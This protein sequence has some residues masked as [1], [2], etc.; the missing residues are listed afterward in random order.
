MSSKR[1]NILAFAQLGIPILPLVPGGSQPA[2]SGRLNGPN[3]DHKELQR[4]FARHPQSNY[5][6]AAGNGFFLV[7]AHGK[8]GKENL[9]SLATRHGDA[10]P[11]TVT[12]RTGDVQDYVFRCDGTHVRNSSGRL[13]KGI[14]VFGEG[15]YVVGPGST[16]SGAKCRFVQGLAVDEVE[17]APAP[18]WLL[19]AV[20][21]EQVPANTTSS[22]AGAVLNTESG[23]AAERKSSGDIAVHSNE[24]ASTAAPADVSGCSPIGNKRENGVPIS[25]R[26]PNCELHISH[27][28]ELVRLPIEAVCIDPA[29]PPCDPQ[30]VRVLADSIRVLGLRTPISVRKVTKLV[31]GVSMAALMLVAG[32]DRYEATKS[33]GWDFIDAFV[34]E[35]DVKNARLWQIAENVH[36]HDVPALERAELID[37]FDRL[38]EESVKGGQVAHP[39][40]GGRQPK[41]KGLSKAAKKLGITRE[42][43][44]RA[45]D[46]AGLSPEAKAKVKELGL[47][48]NQAALLKIAQEKVPHAQVA[49]A[50]EIAARKAVSKDE[51]AKEPIQA[52][53]SAPG[54]SSETYTVPVESG[55]PAAPEMRLENLATTAAAEIDR[56]K[57]E[58][59]DK[60]HRLRKAEEEL[61]VARLPSTAP[62]LPETDPWDIPASL[63][64]R[65]LSP[66][67]EQILAVLLAKWNSGL[68][69]DFG[70][71][72]PVVRERFLAEVRRG[73]SDL[74]PIPTGVR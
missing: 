31:E 34:F 54:A 23:D 25:K 50:Q 73:A 21:G 58:L 68:H 67:N 3:T 62:M 43:V 64:R 11:K 44:R 28:M 71:A 16:I 72:P 51:L 70:Q 49:K 69:S 9:R 35:G 61:A 22:T 29:R 63:D 1:K 57:A 27:A 13:G 5:G 37:E 33:L 6:V 14:G 40:P 8:T 48:D 53:S 45:R 20:A 26:S 32:H 4:F 42:K 41:D 39:V 52:V 56:L 24:E 59:A 74:L 60:T 7:S 36:R 30:N 17:I 65:A 12:F 15:G 19:K 38:L 46:V 2:F 10:L 66:E 47:E 55:P 18:T